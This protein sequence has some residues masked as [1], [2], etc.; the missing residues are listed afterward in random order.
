[1]KLKVYINE[2]ENLPRPFIAG[3]LMDI[4]DLNNFKLE[5]LLIIKY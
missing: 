2:I 4:L 3:V 1:M 5:W